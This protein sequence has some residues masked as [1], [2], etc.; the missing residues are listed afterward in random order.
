MNKSNTDEKQLESLSAL[1]DNHWYDDDE[2]AAEV[3]ASLQGQK[4]SNQ[5]LREKFERYHLVRD[6]MHNEV[7]NADLSGFSARVAAAIADEPAIVS[8]AGMPRKEETIVPVSGSYVETIDG[9]ADA[10]SVTSAQVQSTVAL[11]EQVSPVHSLADARRAKA[12]SK[13]D[14]K[15]DP[16]TRKSGGFWSGRV[17]AGVGG[18]AVAASAAMVALLGYNL[19]E[20]QNAAPD[21][22]NAN[23]VAINA[24]QTPG[25][26]SG[27]ST[28]ANTSNDATATLNI[29]AQTGNAQTVLPVSDQ[30]ALQQLQNSSAANAN[31]QFVSNT[32]TYWVKE[33]EARNPVLEKRLNHLLSQ[34]IESSPT[35]GRLG[36]MLPYSR[37]AGYDTTQSSSVV[38]TPADQ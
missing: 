13:A 20:Q 21:A 12:E 9:S 22:A 31:L 30:Q 25:I 24:E 34:H 19:L 32:S 26:D 36:G 29:L 14:F 16:E 35:A 11:D 6:V 23:Q 3:L 8:P 5:Y 38:E 37:L 4:Q 28:V 27:V 1:I 2:V 7:S 18:F 17:G 10:A 15:S 33:G